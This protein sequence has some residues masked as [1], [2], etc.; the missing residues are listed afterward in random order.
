LGGI[1]EYYLSYRLENREIQIQILTLKNQP[2][3]NAPIFV[4]ISALII[5]TIQLI[6]TLI[7]EIIRCRDRKIKVQINMCTKSEQ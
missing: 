5:R 7:L 3:Y 2:K 6:N 1:K 4:F